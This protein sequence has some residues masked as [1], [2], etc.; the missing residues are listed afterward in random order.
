MKKY[1]LLFLFHLSLT[2]RSQVTFQER[3]GTV[4]KDIGQSIVAVTDSTF[5]ICADYFNTYV[6]YGFFLIKI[7]GHGNILWSKKYSDSTN[8]RNSSLIKTSDNG[9]AIVSNFGSYAN[10]DYG[11]LFTKTDSMGNILWHHIYPGYIS[12]A[13]N[14]IYELNNGNGYMISAVNDVGPYG[15]KALLIKTDNQGYVQWAKTFRVS[16]TFTTGCVISPLDN[17]SFL[18][19]ASGFYY[20]GDSSYWFT[21]RIDALGNVLNLRNS[22]NYEGLQKTHFYKTG[23]NSYLLPS[24]NSITCVDSLGNL[25]WQKKFNIPLNIFSSVMKS[26]GNI[27]LTGYLSGVLFIEVDTSGSIISSTQFDGSAIENGL[28]LCALNGGG[29][30]IAGF[31]QSFN[32]DTTDIYVI[33]TDSIGISGCNEFPFALTTSLI[34]NLTSPDAVLIDTINL[35]QFSDSIQENSVTLAKNVLCFEITPVRE[36][37]FCESFSITPNPARETITVSSSDLQTAQCEIFN[38]QGVRMYAAKLIYGQQK[39]NI[40]GF[41]EGVYFIRILNAADQFSRMLIVE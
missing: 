32:A 7:D 22:L 41:P 2:A 19:S 36:V 17:G 39:I 40:S 31:T 29:A 13:N 28:S 35:V 18:F 5:M 1:F 21:S 27:L 15:E 33:R 9:F 25:I 10:P 26:N 8:I 16:D 14:Q 30:L 6:E 23:N 4:H 24:D 38:L 37:L 3:I 20:S 11:L 34:T 12:N